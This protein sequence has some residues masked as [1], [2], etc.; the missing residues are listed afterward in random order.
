MNIMKNHN[1]ILWIY[2]KTPPCFA[3]RRFTKKID[4]ILDWTPNTNHTGLYVAKEK[5]Y[6]KDAGLDVDI[7]LPPED[8]SSDLIINGKAPFGIYFQDSMAK[9]LDKGAGI[10]AIAA[11]VEHNTSGIISRKD[12]AI[13]SPKD[14]VGKKY[15]TWNDPIEL[16]MIKSMMKKEGA[17]FNQ[18][19]LVPNSDSN[20]ITPIENKVFD[21][22]WIYHGWDGILAEQKGM[23][24][25]FFYMKDFVPAFDYYSP[26]KGYQY[27]IEHP[28]E[29]A[30]ILIKQAP[31][32]ANQR[33]FVLASQ[34]YLSSQYASDKDKW[35]QFDSKRWNAF[36]AWAKEQG[37]VSNDLEDKGFTNELVGD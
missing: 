35:G 28:E 20:S 25:N 30:D 16:E 6:F 22:A 31:A 13:T 2:H 8:S 27:A 36:Y 10:T 19:K 5:G 3:E 17:D 4:F 15:G 32:L 24:T 1:E 12:A 11:I 21:A 34:K 23:K 14:L 26:V 7:K 33:D 37:L 29:A 18:V 9:K